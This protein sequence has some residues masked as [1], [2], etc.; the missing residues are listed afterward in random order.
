MQ[1]VLHSLETTQALILKFIDVNECADEEPPCDL[2]ADCENTV[3]SF[4]C[5]CNEGYTAEGNTCNGKYL[6]T[7]QI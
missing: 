1:K 7:I 3:G 6:W 5:Y 2:N 4:Q